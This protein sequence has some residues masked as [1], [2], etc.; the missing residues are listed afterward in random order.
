MSNVYPG[1]SQDTNFDYV[2]MQLDLSGASVIA[3]F[4][5]GTTIG[6]QE[7]SPALVYEESEGAAVIS[8]RVISSQELYV[9]KVTMGTPTL[10]WSK[11]VLTSSV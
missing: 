2:T 6:T 10:L 7:T 11:K 5:F 9:A 8:L 4:G 3:A 1:W